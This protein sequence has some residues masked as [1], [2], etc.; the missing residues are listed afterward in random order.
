[1][2]KDE[3]QA[4]VASRDASAR[5]LVL[6]GPGTG[7]TETVALRLRHLLE[8][9]VGPAQILVLSFSRSAVRTV[10]DRLERFAADSKGVVED[11]RHVSI[12]TFDSWS[13]RLLR[14]L[15]EAPR[16]LL[17]L[18][19]DGT[20]D[21]LVEGMV[22]D[23][24]DDIVERLAGVRHLVIDEFQDLSGVRGRLVL[25]LLDL[26]TPK[27]DHRVGFTMLGDEAQAIYGFA[28]RN[29]TERGLPGVT[30]TE[31]LQAVR[32]R[33]GAALV[34][35]SL[36]TNYRAV[37]GL[38]NLAVILRR[39]LSRSHSNAIKLDAIRKVL[40]T[41]PESQDALGPALTAKLDGE[42]MAILT[43]T[44]GEAIR[45]WQAIMG[46]GNAGPPVRVLL[47]GTD[48]SGRVPA[49]VG[50]TLGPVQGDTISRQRFGR[51]Y[52]LLY[53]GEGAARAA[54]L[55]VPEEETAWLR[56][57][58]AAQLPDSATTLNLG[59][60]RSRLGWPDLF[61]D[62]QGEH[63]CSLTIMTV[64]QSKG[65]EFANVSL[66]GTCVSDGVPDSDEEILEEAS[67]LFVGFTRAGQTLRRLPAGDLPR[68]SV[69]TFAGGDRRRWRSRFTRGPNNT[70]F[71]LE[72]GLAGD[73]SPT[74]FIDVRL[75]QSDQAVKATQ[76]LLA[77]QAAT[78]VGRK[79]M[80]CKVAE[81]GQGPN[82]FVYAVHLQEGNA[83]DHLLG[84][85]SRALTF[86]LLSL[87][88]KQFRLPD[89]IYNLRITNVVTLGHSGDGDREGLAA[90]WSASGFWLGVSICGTGDFR[91][92]RNAN[93]RGSDA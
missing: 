82:R 68:I 61:P 53:A 35:T 91:P 64:H 74:S 60:L 42:S 31:L 59:A 3:K 22:G 78:L 32:A 83:P 63:E 71:N 56:L 47:H 66:L 93:L 40:A 38:A 43:R 11:L 27:D 50:A 29:Q 33:Y 57:L 67:V 14:Q 4:E 87:L 30:T 72:M 75:H 17:N 69:W 88:N 76:T 8:S 37:P 12:R 9:G 1:M 18:G 92:W 70:W 55:A 73:L 80:L 7:K 15:G 58:R 51:V 84:A 90:P 62:D 79:V 2:P 39:I 34:E 89:K 41:V 26:L 6:A 21:R 28:L 10:A 77:E 5:Q 54:A 13:F 19:F 65:R 45:V 48:S 36:E 81:P 49:W 85:T 16:E 20:I 86:D 24:R 23:R 52:Q 44:N 25:A 46:T